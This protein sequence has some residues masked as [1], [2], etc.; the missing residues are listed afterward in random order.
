MSMHKTPLTELERSGL[1]AHGLVCDA[2]SQLSDAFRLGM[3]WSQRAALS[4]EPNAATAKKAQ[5]P[6][7]I[8]GAQEPAQAAEQELSDEPIYY[9]RDNHTFV[10]LSDDIKE[11]LKQIKQSIDEGHDSGMLYSKRKGF[12]CLHNNYKND[13]PTYLANCKAALE[14]AHS[15]KKTT[16]AIAQSAQSAI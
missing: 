10:R 16:T 8:N 9:M 4:Q 12:V 13:Q 6:R 5:W 2:P 15:I 11:A 3:A 1:V 14:A 7:L